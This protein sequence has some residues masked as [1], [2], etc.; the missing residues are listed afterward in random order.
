MLISILRWQGSNFEGF[1]VFYENVLFIAAFVAL[2]HSATGRSSAWKHAILLA[3]VL[4]EAAYIAGTSGSRE[5]P[6]PGALRQSEL[7]GFVCATRAG[8]L[9]GNRPSCVIDSSSDRRC[10]NGTIPLLRNRANGFSRRDAGRNGLTRSGRLPRGK[11]PGF[12]A[13]P[14]RAGRKSA[15]DCDGGLQS[16]PGPEIHRPRRARSLQLSARECLAWDAASDRRPSSDRSRVR[17]LLLRRQALH[18]TRGKHDRAVSAMAQHRALG[19]PAIH[20]GNRSVRDR[21]CS[22]GWAQ[23]CSCLPG[24]DR[25]GAIPRIA[26]SRSPP[27][28]RPLAWGFMHWSTTTGRRRSWPWVSL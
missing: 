22:L 5:A 2:A 28:L 18:S 3:V 9:C 6:A 24:A 27:C 8:D 11:T 10:R 16:R 7:P 14:H 1:Y 4:I 19:I 26:L 12:I 15:S 13:G 17:P 20:G 23:V 21:C 25:A